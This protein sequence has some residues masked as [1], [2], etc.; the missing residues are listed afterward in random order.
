M[1]D[2]TVGKGQEEDEGVA[3]I[4]G[5]AKADRD[6]VAEA[7]PCQGH[8]WAQPRVTPGHKC[9]TLPPIRV[10]PPLR[11]SPATARNILSPA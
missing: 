10:T 4:G 5:Q 6:R 3:Y 8:S 11:H 7:G 1:T 2:L 9:V